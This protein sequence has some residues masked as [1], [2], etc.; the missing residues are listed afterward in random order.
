MF[1]ISAQSAF[2][3]PL[4]SKI[5]PFRQS[6]PSNAKPIK[7]KGVLKNQSSERE[8]FKKRSTAMYENSS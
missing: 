7:W 4:S 1:S 5:S 8:R 6:D 3:A 2:F